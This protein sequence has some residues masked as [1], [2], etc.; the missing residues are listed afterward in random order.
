M[1][2]LDVL[3]KSDALARCFIIQR[4]SRSSLSRFCI[5]ITSEPQTY[6]SS[7]SQ[8]CFE[9]YFARLHMS[10][11]GDIC[12]YIYIYTPR[13]LVRSFPNTRVFN[14]SAGGW[15]RGV[16]GAWV[17]GRGVPQRCRGR[18]PKSS[19]RGAG[20]GNYRCLLIFTRILRGF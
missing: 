6:L 8:Y 14:V 13:F 10:R 12:I 17:G 19:S 16:G 18:I 11:K 9:L 15:G 1:L 5:V 2:S 7:E 20:A 3:L 4:C